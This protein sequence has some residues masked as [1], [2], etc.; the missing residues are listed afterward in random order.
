MKSRS[1]NKTTRYNNKSINHNSGN[2]SS[3]IQNRNHNSNNGIG[4]DS[5]SN[6]SNSNSNSNSINDSICNNHCNSSHADSV[7]YANKKYRDGV[8]RLLFSDKEKL[9]E[10]Y[11]AL[12]NADYD[13]N[14]KIEIQTLED[15]IFGK[16]KNDLAFTIDDNRFVV[17]IEHQSSENPN[18]PLRM[19][20]YI[21]R[22]YEKIVTNHNLYGTKLI[23]I[24]FPEFYVLYN[25][26]G[27][28]PEERELRLSDAYLE[29]AGKSSLELK[30]R[31]LNVNFEKHASILSRCKTLS[32]Y[33]R[34]VHTVRKFKTEEG[35]ELEAAIKKVM[36]ICIEQG[37]L[38]E[39]L[40][41]HGSEVR[42][43]IFH[44]LSDE[45]YGRIR[46]EDGYEKGYEAGIEKGIEKGLERGIEKGRAES[47]EKILKSQEQIKKS[48]EQI[49]QLKEELAKYVKL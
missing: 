17:L 10:L 30:I 15:A 20:S 25:G 27:Q 16:V 33:S 32:E 9:L 39:F 38:K 12:E 36:N 23:R 49:K 34:F 8:F 21:A 43:M 14:V 4:S 44:E 18:M 13:S 19:L 29:G 48:E 6:S 3:H 1:R 22:V 28:F 41:K 37:V 35:L 42:N 46:E 24:P 47:Y 26:K 11:N 45:E 31:V 40:S 2:N 5:N 7:N